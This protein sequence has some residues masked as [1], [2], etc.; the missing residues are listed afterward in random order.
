VTAAVE[1][2]GAE[3]DLVRV[4]DVL[5]DDDPRG[6]R[7]LPDQ[8]VVLGPIRREV[9]R[10]GA[11]RMARAALRFLLR[12]GGFRA[13]TVLRDGRRIRGRLWDA[14]LNEGF[15]LRFTEA[16]RTFWLGAARVLPVLARAVA[17]SDDRARQQRRAVRDMIP[18]GAAT[19]DWILYAMALRRIAGLVPDSDLREALARKLRL[20][21]PL[22]TL[23][24]LD[25]A[26]PDAEIEAR[27][28]PLASPTGQRLLECVDDALAASLGAELSLDFLEREDHPRVVARL[29]STERVLRTHVALLHRARRLDLT[30]PLVAFFADLCRRTEPSE[31]RRKVAHNG[32]I[33]GPRAR[34][35][36]LA[37]VSRLLEVGHT[38]LTLRD[39]LAGERY[40]DDRYEEAQ[41]FLGAVDPT[42]GIFRARTVSSI[43]ALSG[44]VGGGAP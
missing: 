1:L 8:P 31:L 30:R 15:A 37:G 4:L 33:E 16:S 22:A 6:R 35:E 25:G 13:R 27:L 18:N 44:I 10:A 11:D 40:G 14:P 23:L 32:R 43:F 5:L 12:Q 26:A 41:L 17:G 42:L 19:G 21:S 7:R 29:A 34:D 2:T 38:L 28:A 9:L 36:V 24:A 39:E 20:A 3:A